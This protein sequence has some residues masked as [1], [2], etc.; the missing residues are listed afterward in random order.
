V[1]F[2]VE[3]TGAGIPKENIKRVFEPFFTTKQMGRG[4]GLGLAVS[5]GIA[6]MHR[7]NIRL[8]SNA[9][10]SAGPTG[11]TFTV[12]LPRFERR[13]ESMSFLASE[14]DGPKDAL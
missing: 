9:D 11:T 1:W 5:Y 2:A 3:D 7:G 14:E 8:K 4:T 13:E 6:K 10:P 12:T